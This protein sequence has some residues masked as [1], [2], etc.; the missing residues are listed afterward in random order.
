MSLIKELALATNLTEGEAAIRAYL[1]AHPEH[2][3]NMT[4]D[5]LGKATHTSAS[6][7]MRFC[8]KLGCG[9]YPEFKIQFLGDLMS[10][11]SFSPREEN[12]LSDGKENIASLL[13]VVT[14]M[15]TQAID[16]TRSALSYPQL[17]R[18]Q[19]MLLDCPYIDFYAYDTKQHIAGYASNLFFHAGK[20]A[21]TYS[22]TNVQ[23]L[24]ALSAQTD[25]AAIMISQ[26]GENE[27]LVELARILRA[28]NV[29]TIVMTTS[30]DAPLARLGHECLL[31][32]AEQGTDRMGL[33]SFLSSCKYLIDIMYAIMFVERYDENVLL[34]DDMKKVNGTA[35][36]WPTNCAVHTKNP[37]W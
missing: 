24:S 1:Q 36:G 33:C 13:Q 37:P 7:V 18:V 2:L 17:A 15:Q 21:R 28:K 26:T 10:G 30:R 16:A 25:H 23:V 5:A 12:R 31:A 29:R 34:N 19:H 32:F 27:R 6:T 11:E 20:I 4:C 14:D 35:F 22:E 3:A 9:G 8:H